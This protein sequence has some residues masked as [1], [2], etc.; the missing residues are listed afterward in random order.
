MQT[1]FLNNYKVLLAISDPENDLEVLEYLAESIPEFER[2][3]KADMFTT[4][5]MVTD[6]T[7]LAHMATFVDSCAE[8]IEI[9]GPLVDNFLG[10]SEEARRKILKLLP[11]LLISQGIILYKSFGYEI[12]ADQYAN[13]GSVDLSKV[14]LPVDLLD[15]LNKDAASVIE[16]ITTILTVFQ[17]FGA[18]FAEYQLGDSQDFYDLM[19]ELDERNLTSDTVGRLTEAEVNKILTESGYM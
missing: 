3:T 2:I 8:M 15:K 6:D 16:T 14:T 13:F 5:Q 19:A 12:I 4:Y 9:A 18:Y 10:I 11:N 17:T 7:T 1:L